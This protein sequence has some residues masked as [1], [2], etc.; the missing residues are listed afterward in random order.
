MTI[1]V[2]LSVKPEVKGF[3]D[4]ATN[5]ISYVVKDQGSTACAIVD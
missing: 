3:F 1:K 5:T 4:P 2:D